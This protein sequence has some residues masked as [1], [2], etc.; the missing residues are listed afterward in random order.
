M[1][2]ATSLLNRT[3]LL[4]FTG[5]VFWLSILFLIGN[6]LLQPLA[7]WIASINVRINDG[8]VPSGNPLDMMAGIQLVFGM[9][10]VVFL[11]A[12]L[13]SYKNKEQS[14]DFMHALP[15]KR[16]YL[17]SHALLSGF[18]NILIPMVTTSIILFFERHFLVFDISFIDIITWGAY[19][20]FVLMTVFSV[21]VFC[22][23]LVNN[24]LVH[25]QLILIVFF[26]PVIFWTLNVAVADALFEGVGIMSFT[27]N[28]GNLISGVVDNT[29][30]IF[31][32]QQIYSGFV[33][34]KSF[35][36][37][38]FAVFLFI[39]SYI[40]YGR[41]QNEKV[42]HTFNQSWLRNILVAFLSISGML[43]VGLIISVTL[44][45][46]LLVF[47]LSFLFGTA[48]VYI[49]IEMSFQGTVRLER[50][51]KSMITTA[52]LLILFWTVFIIG[53][54]QYVAYVPEESEIDSVRVTNSS[55]S[56]YGSNG[57]VNGEMNEDYLYIDNGE[58]I[59][60]A[61]QAHEEAMAGLA[62]KDISQGYEWIEV[63][64][65]M[66]NGNYIN[67][68][69]DDLEREPYKE[70]LGKVNSGEYARNNDVFFN[71]EDPSKL[72]RIEISAPGGTVTVEEASSFIEE[73]QRA[74]LGVDEDIPANIPNGGEPL[75]NGVAEFEQ[76]YY[77]GQ[78]SIYNPVLQKAIK[79]EEEL[80]EFLGVEGSEEMYTMT[81]DEVDRQKF[82]QDYQ[83]LTPKQFTSKYE[84]KVLSDSQMAEIVKIVDEG[85]L[86][87]RGQKVL[88]YSSVA[89][90][91][92]DAEEITISMN[93]EFN[94]LGIE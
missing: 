93:Q 94:I 61:V 53:W 91:W 67:R 6:I 4:H 68:R 18:I 83:T 49:A 70:I 90:N 47:I 40:L 84:L 44:P 75:L 71:V 35:M 36:W 8:Y 65:R 58:V 48:F 22:G 80:A 1:R 57:K 46:G 51:I 19:S 25:L 78:A 15:M 85:K 33:F 77:S 29:F 88:I 62:L 60:E 28:G 87:G 50:N 69:F 86:D 37:S 23:F 34:W 9:V 5:S 10:Y 14:I 12:F 21:S 76:S 52:A 79:G 38:L 31:A 13:F 45:N 11:A 89:E 2:S 63:S 73:Y 26:L 16:H 42:H 82:F 64:Y 92:L 56:S 30:P 72:L 7:L 32:I 43:L 74:M 17:L 24:I 20:V 39:G 54:N 55:S 66:K 41:N 81:L 59:A 27:G 3:L